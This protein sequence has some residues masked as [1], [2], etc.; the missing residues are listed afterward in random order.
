MNS[1]HSPVNSSIEENQKGKIVKKTLPG[2]Q[3]STYINLKKDVVWKVIFRLFRRYFKEKSTRAL[4]NDKRQEEH[5]MNLLQMTGTGR[6]HEEILKEAYEVFD[7]LDLPNE[8]RN[9]RNAISCLLLVRHGKMTQGRFIH[10]N[11]WGT[12]KLYKGVFENYFQIFCENSR[13]RRFDF[14]SCPLIKHLWTRFIA[15]NQ[16]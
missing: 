2:E 14:Y 12:I 6:T 15:Q 5:K 1:S 16:F 3:R 11:Y 13:L 4:V 8:F 9:D 7:S 10:E